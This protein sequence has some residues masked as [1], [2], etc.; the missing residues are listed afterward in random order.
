MAKASMGAHAKQVREG[1]RQ[2]EKVLAVYRK[3]VPPETYE[4][5]LTG[6]VQ[7]ACLVDDAVLA[8]R[9]FDRISDAESRRTAKASCAQL[10]IALTTDR[11]SAGS[12]SKAAPKAGN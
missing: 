1:L 10:G 6:Y 11:A 12:A 3:Q 5:M 4:Q 2:A 8:Q 9:F 7:T